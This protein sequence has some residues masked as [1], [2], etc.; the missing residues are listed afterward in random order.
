MVT[1]CIGLYNVHIK[2]RHSYCRIQ[3]R[4]VIKGGHEMTITCKHPPRNDKD[5]SKIV[6]HF[7]T[8]LTLIAVVGFIWYLKKNILA[9]PKTEYAPSDFLSGA[10]PS[11][12]VSLRSISH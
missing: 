9:Y 8:P 4:R 7:V 3:K 5:I 10:F 12:G 1:V 2:K 11:A 6:L